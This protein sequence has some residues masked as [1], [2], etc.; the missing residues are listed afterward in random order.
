[1]K[2]E[3]EEKRVVPNSQARFRKGKGKGKDVCTVC[4]LQGG[5]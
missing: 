4:R 3:I 5:V 1:M 2:G